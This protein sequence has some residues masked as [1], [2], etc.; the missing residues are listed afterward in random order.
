MK[1]NR[2]D[3]LKKTAI[4]GAGLALAAS[5]FGRTF[6][7]LASDKKVRL[8]VI[9]TGSRGRYLMELLLAQKVNP[10]YE[11]V[12]VCDN[13]G[14]SLNEAVALAKRYKINPKTYTEYSQ[15]INQSPVDG[16]I[17]ATPLHQHAHITIDSLNKGIHVLCEKA[18]AR[19]LDDTKAMYD[20]HINS[21]SILL[22]GHQRL[23]SNQYI[24][25]LERIHNG[26]IGV[27]GQMKAYWHRNHNW[28]RDVPDNQAD[29]E[30]K[31]NWR[32][33]K[34]YSA[35]LLT[36]LMSHQLQVANWAMKKYPVSVMATGSIQYYKDGREVPDN[37]AA[38]FSYDDGTQFIYD[39]M[40]INKAEGCEEHIIGDYATM[41]LE[42]NNILREDPI[43]P[44][45]APGIAQLIN[46]IQNGLFKSA[47]IGGSSWA[48]ETAVSYNGEE[49]YKGQDGDG[50]REEIVHFIDYIQQKSS[51]EWMTKEGYYTSIWSLLTEKSIE[52]GERITCPDKYL[53]G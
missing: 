35:G 51:P 31:I 5:P 16:V 26:E 9:G 39:S 49:I 53:I 44:E 2:R 11:L 42:S 14:P 45:P 40:T 50:T 12:A 7:A 24:N 15:L 19:T 20:A 46:D 17:I 47:P 13:Y 48:A 21:G 3:F 25:A 6:A 23:H 1:E 33:Y 34:E 4:A 36:E 8:A 32:L 10:N 52:T 30:R 38:I 37:M 28:R 27:I 41:K 18:M 43:K 29:L 22:I